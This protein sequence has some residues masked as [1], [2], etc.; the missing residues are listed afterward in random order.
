MS[1]TGNRFLALLHSS[2]EIPAVV[3]HRGDSFHAPE[4]TLEAAALALEAGADGWEI[5]VQLTRDEIPVLLHDPSLVRTTDVAKRFRSDPRARTGFRVSE[6]DLAEV[7]SLDAGSWFVDSSGSPR[8]AREFGTLDRLEPSSI[9]HF[10]S[11]RVAIPTLADALIFTRDHDWLVNVEIKSFPESPPRLVQR[12]LEVI[13]ETDAASCVLISSFDHIDLVA[14]DRPGRQHALGILTSTP[15][16][17]IDH[18]A[19]ELV[20]ADTVHVSAAVLGSQS[21]RYRHRPTG[22]SLRTDGLAE[23]KEGGVPILV[24]TVNEHGR[25]SL[26]EHLTQIGVDGLFTDDPQGIRRYF[27]ANAPDHCGGPR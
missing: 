8:C 5:D 13:A 10:R 18:Y 14:A 11:G 12:V 20:G 17:R 2:R 27:S 16:Y 7:L 19:T 21:I 3:G 4:N 26:A 9:E 15:L 22:G 25:G 23:L 24:Y 1:L 6:F